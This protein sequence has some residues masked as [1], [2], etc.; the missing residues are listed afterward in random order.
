MTAQT[1]RRIAT[2]ALGNTAVFPYVLVRRP[3][4]SAPPP[5]GPDLLQDPPSRAASS[6]SAHVAGAGGGLRVALARG[7]DRALHQ[8]VPLAGEAVGVLDRRPRRRVDQV[9]ADLGQVRDPGRADG[10]V[11]VVTSSITLMN[12]QPS[13]S[14][15][16]N[17]SPKTSK[18][19]SSR[20][21]G[22]SARGGPPRPAASRASSAPRGA[23]GTP[24]ISSSLDA[25]WRYSVIFATPGLGDDRVHPDRP[26][27]VA[28]EELVSGLE[29]PLAPGR[30]FHP[31]DA[32]RSEDRRL[33]CRRPRPSC[34]AST[35]SPSVACA[36]AASS[37][38]RHQ[39]RASCR[40]LGLQRGSSAASTGRAVAPRRGPPA[41]GRSAC[42]RAPGRCAGSACSPSSPSVKP[43]TPT[44]TRSPGV[45][46]R[47]QLERGVGDLALRVVLLDRLDH[48]A[49][50]VDP[51]EV[52]VRRA[53]DLV[54]QRLDEVR[55]AERVDRVRH[56]GLVGDDLLRAQ[57]D[58]ARPSS[59]G[60]ASASS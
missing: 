23:P 35:I 31:A 25:K 2:R 9:D 47:L 15:R 19:A 57:R 50:L 60:S 20:S 40:R 48:P 18:I 8:D 45:D 28:A 12:E 22:S 41:R 46:R 13:K 29:D 42:A 3:A 7:D 10:V 5:V 43:L 53:L 17:H 16:A 52:L 56:A 59:V 38:V 34:S 36:R 58:R 4:R 55:A 26:R 54:G 6:S 37:S 49:E 11:A 21:R 33:A 39:V 24:A 14:S 44:T 32:R 27:P 1:R 30:R 51:L